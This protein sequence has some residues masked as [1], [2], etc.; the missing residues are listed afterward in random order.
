MMKL[1]RDVYPKVFWYAFNFGII[2]GAL[3]VGGIYA[4]RPLSIPGPFLVC[5]NF[6]L[7]TG[8]MILSVF[9]HRQ[10]YKSI[11]FT[12]AREMSFIVYAVAALVL[13]AFRAHTGYLNKFNPIAVLL[14]FGMM[15]G[16]GRALS[17]IVA[18]NMYRR[19]Y[20]KE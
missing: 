17:Y 4:K 20:A 16:L 13:F 2:T 5:I 10:K 6:L 18:I 1:I 8:A 3:I 11:D 15:Y 12:L 19:I 7:V 9:V 14:A